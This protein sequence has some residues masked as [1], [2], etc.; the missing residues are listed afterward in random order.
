MANTPL[1]KFLKTN[2][3]S[4]YAFPGAAED[5]SAAYQ[6]Q[7]YK[8]YFSK[9]VLLNLP[10]QNTDAGSQ[11]NSNEIYWDFDNAFKRSIQSTPATSYK[12]Q[13]VESLR[14]YVANFE[15]T[16]K[17]SKLNNTE[18]Y[19][20]NTVLDTPTEKIF[21]KWCKQ[22]GLVQFEPANNGDEYFGNLPEFE[23]N[24]LTDDTYFPEIL[25]RE[26]EVVPYSV[27]GVYQSPSNTGKLEMELDGTSNFK[28][29]DVIKVYNYTDSNLINEL[30]GTSS[31][32]TIIDLIEQNSQD[33]QKLV[34]DKDTSV[35]DILVT[36]GFLAK[37]EL[38]Y[39]KLV[40]YIG[41]VNGINNV[42]NANR[43]Y[44]EVYAHVP[45]HTGQTPDIL[46]RT[47][48]DANYKPNL[49]FPI[50]PSQYQPEIL[51]A[52]LFTNP[53]VNAPQN[54][55][56]NYYAQFD[57]EDFTYELS[58]GDSIRRSGDYYGV[59]GDILIP[60]FDGS[61]LDGISLD[62]DT[63]HYVKMNIIDREISNFDQFNALE[64]NNQP[65]KDFEFNSI[66]WYYTVEDIN[67]NQT[68]NLYGIS[69]LDNP[70]NNTV[71][72]EIFQGN[73][74][75]VPLFPKLAANDDQDGLSYAFSLNLNFSIITENPQ[76]TYNPESINSLFSFN[77]FNE[78]MRRLG[79]I[80]ES[81]LNII[82]NQTRVDEEVAN[83]KQLLYTQ[84]DL[85]II[86]NR[87][88]N[89]EN[90][91]RLYSTN[92]IVDSDSISVN[93][94]TTLRPPRLTLTSVDPSYNEV[95]DVFSDRLYN[96]SG[97]IPY[98]VSISPNKNSLI[99]FINNDITDFTLPRNQKLALVIDQ[100][101]SFRQSLDII[102][103][104]DN[105][106]TQNKQ[107]EIF[108]RFKYGTELSTPVETKLLETI[109]LPVYFNSTTQKENTSKKWK[110]VA[111]DIDLGRP[112]RLN[113]GG[114]LELPMKS[115]PRM[116]SN[117]FKVGDCYQIGDFTIGTS[118]E[119][120]FS[121]Q[122]KINF[123]DSVNSFVYF[124]VSNNTSLISYG[125]SS[126]LP[127]QFNATASTSTYL[128]SN[129]P[130]LKLNKGVKI[131]VT[132]VSE[133]LQT[134]LTERYLIQREMY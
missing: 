101:L 19:Y 26:R 80:N 31:S 49:A 25:W 58:S 123:V 122:Y 15:V 21:W 102:I 76:D 106:A 69:I 95:I 72:S 89:L 51:G 68:S 17:E 74:L 67:G 45:A 119:I 29:G 127:L 24:N 2:G 130:H 10:K 77:L 117:A 41:E 53:I 124:D 57:T 50:L 62:F 105:S 47:K 33:G 56:G 4:F 75:R 126:S 78:A 71:E 13:L 125:A 88:S 70:D 109:D 61:F 133:S 55:P 85:Q 28:V 39:H 132:R 79:I 8:M 128:L 11:T 40:Q 87:I 111:F 129:I 52:E 107:L 86:N 46:F 120:D 121:G 110:N 42:N 14:N 134:E 48:A 91:L 23:R 6:N 65:P 12:D 90:L 35:N 18:Y 103:D 82:A 44:T 36:T 5:I 115:E 73:G 83:I 59:S 112:I 66:L 3:T 98:L 84:T 92:Q 113:T 99:H 63:T 97:I 22:L 64:V 114:I 37:V 30:G 34:F 94:D 16:L 118:S 32:M 7:N 100:D 96:P 54:Y 93:L 104:A 38:V 27:V 43:S 20:D 131:K 108:I 60:T 1:Y 81:F 116:I 9:Y